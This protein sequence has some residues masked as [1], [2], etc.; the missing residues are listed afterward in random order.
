[1]NEKIKQAFFSF[2]GLSV[3]LGSLGFLSG[4][5]Q[6]FVDTNCRL[7]IKWFLLLGLMATSMVIIL[8]KLVYDIW[9]EK[10]PPPYWV[11]PIQ[12]IHQ[13]N[14]IIINKNDNFV[15]SILVSCYLMDGNVE[16]LIGIGMVHLV[17]DS[18]IQIKITKTFFRDSKHSFASIAS[19]KLRIRP[20]VPYSV[21]T[22]LSAQEL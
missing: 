9:T 15:N 4:I 6:L 16:N 7:S 11:Q 14:L 13:Q 17:Q 12:I 5:V 18:I 10:G 1:M 20:V 21:I 19:D 22:E 3:F 8:L 2:S